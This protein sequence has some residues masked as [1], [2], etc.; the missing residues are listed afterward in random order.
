MSET[1]VINALSKFI[2]SMCYFYIAFKDKSH[3]MQ[4]AGQRSAVSSTSDSRARGPWFDAQPDH[5]LS[6][7]RPLIQESEEG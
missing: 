5:I 3:H 6:F 4:E 1:H 2:Y 7:I